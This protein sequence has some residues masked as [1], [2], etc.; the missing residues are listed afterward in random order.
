M[1]SSTAHSIITMGMPKKKTRMF[2][3][4]FSAHWNS[5]KVSD[6][7]WKSRQKLLRTFSQRA[8]H[9]TSFLF[10]LLLSHHTS[11]QGVPLTSWFA[12]LA[13]VGFLSSL[14]WL[15]GLTRTAVGAAAA[16]H[17]G[18]CVLALKGRNEVWQIPMGKMGWSQHPRETKPCHFLCIHDQSSLISSSNLVRVHLVTWLPLGHFSKCFCLKSWYSSVSLIS[19]ETCLE[20]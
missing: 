15:P 8:I 6:S 16:S 4:H 11:A 20:R 7:K 12:V 14:R 2:Q 19:S 1:G 3:L 18:L 13:L 17:P 10:P 9:S 5:C